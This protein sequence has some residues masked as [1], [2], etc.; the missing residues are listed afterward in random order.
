MK[1][2]DTRKRGTVEV[3]QSGDGVEEIESI[4]LGTTTNAGQACSK[5]AFKA[6]V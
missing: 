4:W 1:N 5:G 6:F 2:D 3:E